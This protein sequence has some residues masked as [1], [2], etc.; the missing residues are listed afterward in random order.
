MPLPENILAIESRKQLTDVL[1]SH[2]ISTVDWGI[3][4]TKTPADLYEELRAGE[5]ALFLAASGLQKYITTVKVN[6]FYKDAAGIYRLVEAAQNDFSSGENRWR[7]R[8]L[9]N[10]LSEKRRGFHGESPLEAAQR[11]LQEEIGVTQPLALEQ[12]AEIVHPAKIEP[13]NYSTLPTVNE[14]QYFQASLRAADYHP[15]GYVERQPTKHTF[16][17]WEPVF[18]SASAN[19]VVPLE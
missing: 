2:N 19:V 7:H 5:S 17:H 8:A 10:S 1:V 3:D 12:T 11:A 4:N 14:T 6:I 15:L 16:F 9:H 18:D 13:R